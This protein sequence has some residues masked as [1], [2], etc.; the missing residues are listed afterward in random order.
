MHPFYG[1]QRKK[2]RGDAIFVQRIIGE[3]IL[4]GHSPGQ[5][6]LRDQS[7]LQQDVRERTMVGLRL[8]NRLYELLRR[9]HLSHQENFFQ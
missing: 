1:D 6:I 7:V 5:G 4:I 2:F 8:A 3:A 9:E